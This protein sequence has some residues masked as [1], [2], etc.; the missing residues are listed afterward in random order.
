MKTSTGEKVFQAFLIV[1]ITLLSICMI[2]PFIHVLSI[3]FST[4]PEAIRQGMHW[5]P[6]EVSLYAW[7]RVLADSSIWRALG[8]TICRD[9]FDTAFH[10]DSSI[11]A[12]EKVSSTPQFLH[13]VYRHYDVF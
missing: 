2:Y 6:K 13:D 1:F 3:S 4:A 7:D 5:Y 8:N 11:P 9:V 10:V 12:L